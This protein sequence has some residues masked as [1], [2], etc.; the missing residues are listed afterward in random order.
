LVL[1]L[2]FPTGDVGQLS[3]AVSSLI[4]LARKVLCAE[5]GWL[6][7][8]DRFGVDGAC[9][10]MEIVVLPDTTYV[11]IDHIHDS[12]LIYTDGRDFPAKMAA[13]IQSAAGSVIFV[14]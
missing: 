11:L 7:A 6:E 4:T 1:G 8:S 3:S 2:A 10:E 12:R 9:G 5:L 14:M 13:A